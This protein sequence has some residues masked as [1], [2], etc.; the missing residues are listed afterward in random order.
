MDVI[1]TSWMDS[2][3][4][5][6]KVYLLRIIGLVACFMAV[7]LVLYAHR[8]HDDRRRFA[9]RI[10]TSIGGSLMTYARQL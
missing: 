7:L 4:Q 8:F 5:V 6:S 2:N 10:S 9:T 3:V 1:D